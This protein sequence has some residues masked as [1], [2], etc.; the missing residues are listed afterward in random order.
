[1]KIK[2]F[3]TTVA[4]VAVGL[5]ILT[6]CSE[7]TDADFTGPAQFRTVYVDGSKCIVW[8]SKGGSFG[9]MQCKIN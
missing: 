3:S 2:T 5:G 1:V 7:A 6:G 8:V 4:L 9:T